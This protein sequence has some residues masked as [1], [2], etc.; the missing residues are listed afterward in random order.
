MRGFRG[1]QQIKRLAAA[2]VLA[3]IIPPGLVSAEPVAVRYAE[4][5]V[6][7]FLVLPLANGD[8]IQ[9]VRGNRVTQRLVFHLG[10]A[11]TCGF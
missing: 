7:G 8:L 1:I 4:G 3:A 9:I 6:R 5:T 11:L 2:L 10:M